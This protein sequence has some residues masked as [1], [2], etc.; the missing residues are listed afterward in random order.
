MYKSLCPSIVIGKINLNLFNTV[1]VE[2]EYYTIKS[3]KPHE[4]RLLK[5]L[6]FQYLFGL[7]YLFVF[8]F[9]NDFFDQLSVFQ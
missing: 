6:I 4:K 2:Y 8:H 7:Y 9:L 1:G 3:M 5:L